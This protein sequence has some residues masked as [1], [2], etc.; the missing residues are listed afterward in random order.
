MKYA[1]IKGKIRPILEYHMTRTVEN[2][3]TERH[4]FFC[5]ETDWEI[6]IEHWPH[7]IAD[8]YIGAFDAFA[9][10]VDTGEGKVTHKLFETF[11]EAMDYANRFL[12]DKNENDYYPIVK[13]YGCMFTDMGLSYIAENDY[14]HGKWVDLYNEEYKLEENK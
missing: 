6:D 8:T 9:V 11:D 3:K 14:K 7:K 13:C 2:V 12:M 4:G 1:Y 5:E 10:K